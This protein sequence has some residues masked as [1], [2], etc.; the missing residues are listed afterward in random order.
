MTNADG[1]GYGETRH[2]D[3]LVSIKGSPTLE[4]RI[5]GDVDLA[6]AFDIEHRVG[7]AYDPSVDGVVID[8]SGTTYLDSVGLAMLV[9]ISSR[10]TAARTPMTVIAPDESVARRIINLSGLAT[11]LAVRSDSTPT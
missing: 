4:V 11:Q 6:N 5:D 1:I 8:L 10:L 9:R 7:S 2:G 3:A